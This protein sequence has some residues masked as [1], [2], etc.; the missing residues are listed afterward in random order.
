MKIN[1]K[2]NKRGRPIQPPEKKEEI[3]LN[4]LNEAK[5]PFAEEDTEDNV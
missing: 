2:K 4:I 5:K 3:R 1:L